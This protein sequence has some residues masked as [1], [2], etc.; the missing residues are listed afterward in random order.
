LI[1]NPLGQEYIRGHHLLRTL[2]DRLEREGLACLR[3]DYRGT[4][5]SAGADEDT[6]FTKWQEDV[7]FAHRE[8]A[9][10]AGTHKILWLG[11]R[12]GAAA[13]FEAS[14][15]LPKADQPHGL[16][17]WEPVKCGADYL[18]E[19]RASHERAL[20]L[21][22]ASS[23]SATVH[24]EELI[25]FGM[26]TAMLDEIRQIELDLDDISITKRCIMTSG[27]AWAPG[28]DTVVLEQEFDWTGLSTAAV[29]QEL[30]RGVLD[31]IKAMS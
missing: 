25:G 19:L 29:S 13:A 31:Q 6:L 26:S 8:L 17:L 28:P 15:R 4:G 16:L 23:E 22:G 14:R 9:R 3:F 11:V 18:R 30:V 24:R 1:C 7:A 12:L 2:A 20:A 27:K 5:D 21:E 10:R